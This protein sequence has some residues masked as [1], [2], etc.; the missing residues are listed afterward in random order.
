[1]LVVQRSVLAADEGEV[2]YPADLLDEMRE[3]F[4][5]HG[6]RSPFNWALR[7]RAYGKKVRNSTTSLGY[8]QWS[9]DKESLS[10]KITELRMNGFKDFIRTEVELIQAQLEDLLLLHADECKEDTVPSFILRRLKDNPAEN[11][12]S[13]SFL[14]RPA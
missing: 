2:E 10:Y 9:E 6:S 4:I 3:R 1:M 5:I 11:A 14:T 13:W 7:L 8:I 12:R